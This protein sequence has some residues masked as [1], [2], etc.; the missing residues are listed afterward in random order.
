MA[1][2]AA[3][4][5]EDATLEIRLLSAGPNTLDVTLASWLFN[6]LEMLEI[7]ADVAEDWLARMLLLVSAAPSD[8][9]V[10]V[11]DDTM[12]E[13][14]SDADSRALLTMDSTLLMI[15]LAAW[16]VSVWPRAVAGKRMRRNGVRRRIFDVL[17]VV[18]EEP[19]G[20]A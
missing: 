2:L 15:E 20:F 14:A 11:A 13:A 3:E 17:T 9:P 19:D 7:A 16:E 5:A 1:E 8:S 4:L 10:L 6:S 12:E 18:R